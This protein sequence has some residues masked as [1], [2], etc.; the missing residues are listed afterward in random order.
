MTPREERGLI[1]A[2]TQKLTQKG[3]AW[4]VPSQSGRGKYTVV[5][6]DQE[7]YCSCPDF[8]ATGQPCKHIHAVTFTVQ[9]EH[10]ADGTVTETK[11]ITFTQKQ[12]YKQ[13]W[14]VYDLAQMTE[15]RRF[16][17]LLSDLCKGIQE[18]PA[19]KTGRKPTPLA[20]MIFA[21]AYK[22]YSTVSCR[23]FG[24]DLKDAQEKGTLSKTIHPVT[25]G[26]Y[27]ENEKLTPV[28]VSL[29]T[30]SSLPLR[31]IESDFAVDSTG[32]STSRFVRWFDQKYGVVRIEH[33]WVKA[34]FVCGVKTH[35][36][37]AVRIL[38]KDAADCPQFGPMVKETA[39]NFK[40]GE[41]SAD[42]AYLSAENIETV[43]QAGGTP[44]IAFKDNT[45]GKVG[46]L[47]EKMFH[48][49]SLNKEEYMAHYHKR[50]N[51]ESAVSMVKAKFRDNVRSKTDTAMKNEVLAKILCHNI[52]CLIMSQ[53]ELGIEPV[54]WSEERASNV[55]LAQAN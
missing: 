44:Y 33:E 50:S 13:N 1:I 10:A 19:P 15:K 18:P 30:A 17:E 43:F 55:A 3:K 49:Y 41:V 22:V 11:S 32:F 28:L 51:V 25:V 29:I 16:L 37:T 42:K 14:P 9:R 26:A 24:T 54:F 2:A 35:V 36:I 47:F 4:L 21:A 7:P 39:E 40:I 34:H 48:Y 38:D 27:L 20:D 53:C 8:E 12:T 45:T 46:G 31:V 5:P 6:D 52:C 23:R